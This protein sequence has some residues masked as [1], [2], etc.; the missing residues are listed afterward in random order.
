MA[1]HPGYAATNLQLQAGQMEDSRLK[2][3]TWSLLNN[4]LA[5]SD[6]QGALPGL[7]AATATDVIG[8]EYFGPDGLAGTRGQPA[9][10]GATKQAR[11]PELAKRL[12]EVSEELTGV[13]YGYRIDR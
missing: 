12:W 13:T 7:Y 5:Q 9:R 11:D 1:A 4:A 10:A 3:T 2:R 8:G 6:A